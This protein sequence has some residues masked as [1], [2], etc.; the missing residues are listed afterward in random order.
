MSAVIDPAYV[1]VYNDL[2]PNRDGNGPFPKASS[3]LS[4][5][6][7][8]VRL[9]YEWGGPLFVCQMGPFSIVKVLAECLKWSPFRLTNGPLFA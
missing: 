8:L 4:L 3:R 2:P 1:L 7:L 9:E 6:E 5:G